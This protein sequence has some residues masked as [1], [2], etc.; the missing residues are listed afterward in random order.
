MI[1]KID[2]DAS[3][4]EK[5]SEKWEIRY[6]YNKLEEKISE[7]FPEIK[8]ILNEMRAMGASNTI[9]SGSV[10]TVIGFCDSSPI[11]QK[12][13]NFYSKKQY[14]NCITKTKRRTL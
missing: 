7:T 1:S 8:K 5:F 10:A 12:I 3:K 9:L 4:W 6:C 14:W 11:A 13:S 2:Y